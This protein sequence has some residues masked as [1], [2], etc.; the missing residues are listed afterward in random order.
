MY[1]LFY[2][3]GNANLAPHMALAELA[4]PYEL[5]LVDRTV[6]AHKSP[7]YLRLNPRGLIPTLIDGDRPVFETAAILL[8]LADRHPEA[9]LAPPLGTPERA[10]FYQWLIHLTNTVQ[11]EYIAYY[12][13]ERCITDPALA[14][15]VKAASEAKL[16]AMFDL[17]EST[18]GDGPYLLGGR[19]SMVDFMLF[20]M[21]RWGRNMQRPPRTLP[22]LGRFLVRMLERPSV[23]RAFA[24]EGLSEPWY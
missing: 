15:L 8:H 14:P 3:P 6:N 12:Y 10:T 22:N 4:V 18:L 11:A 24:E 5:V 7:Q 13:P 1:R 20:M 21:A 17:L 16:N 23:Q 9:G 2:Y 19:L